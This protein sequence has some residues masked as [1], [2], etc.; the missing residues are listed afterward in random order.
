MQVIFTRGPTL[1][2]GKLQGGGLNL[3]LKIVLRCIQKKGAK[4][5]LP[6]C[7]KEKSKHTITSVTCV[8]VNTMKIT[9]PF[10]F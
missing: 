9:F 4:P 8:Y 5:S 7:D 10:N 2:A 1:V 3:A 6:K